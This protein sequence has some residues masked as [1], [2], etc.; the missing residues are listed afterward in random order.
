M[1][2]TYP[3]SIERQISLKNAH[4]NKKI[5]TTIALLFLAVITTMSIVA[6]W[7]VESYRQS[8]ADKY[9]LSYEWYE[10]VILWDHY[11]P[12]VWGDKPRTTAEVASRIPFTHPST[13][14]V[15]DIDPNEV[16]TLDGLKQADR[17]CFTLF[18]LIA[19]FYLFE[20]CG[21]LKNK[22]S[23]ALTVFYI[24]A[25]P[26]TAVL[27]A[28]YYTATPVVVVLVNV[29]GAMAFMLLTPLFLLL[30]IPYY[31]VFGSNK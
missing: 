28:L 15:R 19:W 18:A 13:Y 5:A 31:C 3:K 12:I 30:L 29:A 22:L 11:T 7:K 14:A 23:Q 27:C 24:I 9:D 16:A 4:R 6:H 17:V 20:L 8:I 25:W 21:L 2:K 1:S 26:F 10:V